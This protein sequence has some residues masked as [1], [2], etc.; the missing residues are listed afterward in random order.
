MSVPWVTVDIPSSPD[1]SRPE[2][3]PFPSEALFPSE[4]AAW[5][6]ADP[7]SETVYIEID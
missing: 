1:W 3:S 2:R 5:S 7:P 6:V 4:A